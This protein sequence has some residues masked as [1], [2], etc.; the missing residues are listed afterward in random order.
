MVNVRVTKTPGK[1]E[2]TEILA[3][4]IVKIAQGFDTLMAGGLNRRG[5][6][7]LLREGIGRNNITNEQIELVLDALPRLKAWYIRN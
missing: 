5:L 2:S 4:S 3:A 7:A 1:E 6:I